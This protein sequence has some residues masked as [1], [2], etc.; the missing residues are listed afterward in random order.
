MSGHSRFCT[1]VNVLPVKLSLSAPPK[2]MS[3]LLKDKVA[4]ITGGSRGIGQAIAQKFA[5]HGLQI[6]AGV[7]L[8]C[9]EGDNFN[10]FRI[11]LFGL[12]KINNIKRT[13]TYLSD[14]LN[15]IL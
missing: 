13:V 5:E 4:I 6:A 15:K 14:V 10:T 7:P 1:A 8:M 2:K 9:N 11:G 3:N 12:E